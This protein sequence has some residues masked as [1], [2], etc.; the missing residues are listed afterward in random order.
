MTAGHNALTQGG[1]GDT[2]LIMHEDGGRRAQLADEPEEHRRV[3][4][5]VAQR[6]QVTHPRRCWP[7][8]SNRG[9][10]NST[11]ILGTHVPVKEPST[12][13]IA[14]IAISFAPDLTLFSDGQSESG[15]AK[16]LGRPPAY[17]GRDHAA[18]RYAM[19]LLLA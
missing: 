19:I 9:S 5:M 11:H 3:T 16:P 7:K 8:L 17:D 12:A 2:K 15:S 1:T 14:D 10:I 18:I 4:S 6:L 13:S